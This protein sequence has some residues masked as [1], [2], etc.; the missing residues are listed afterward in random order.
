[1]RI[2]ALVAAVVFAGLIGAMAAADDKPDW[3]GKV[4]WAEVPVK[5]YPAVNGGK[6]G[7]IVFGTYEPVKGWE[8][9]KVVLNYIPRAGGSP[10][11][12]E[13]VKLADG[14]FGAIDPKTKKVVPLKLPFE[15]GKWTM[16]VIV[17]YE[18]KEDG[19]TVEAPVQT[20]WEHVE[21]K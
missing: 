13:G 5:T 11:D 8:A 1:M 7:V 14:K 4:G 6:P 9:K 16:R 10:K 15:P 20:S 3:S 19:E 17:T 21:V 18:R 2:R 12:V